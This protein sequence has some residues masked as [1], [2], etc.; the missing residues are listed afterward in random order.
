LGQSPREIREKRNKPVWE[1][2][3]THID[4]KLLWAMAEKG[5][6]HIS[7]EGVGLE[8]IG[9]LCHFGGEK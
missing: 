2:E 6:I 3:S 7:G 8:N 9:D 1:I 4:S 5:W